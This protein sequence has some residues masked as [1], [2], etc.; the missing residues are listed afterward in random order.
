MTKCWNDDPGLPIHTAR[1]QYR[2]EGCGGIG[3]TGEVRR[4]DD[5]SRIIVVGDRY[6][7]ILRAL[8]Y[9]SRPHGKRVCIQCAHAYL[10]PQEVSA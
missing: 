1:Q 10:R 7:E 4:P 9:S 3:D 8:A 6:V 5:C 2:C